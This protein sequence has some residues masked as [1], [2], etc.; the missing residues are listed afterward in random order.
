LT[1]VLIRH[2]YIHI[3]ALSQIQA[4]IHYEYVFFKRISEIISSGIFHTSP[5]QLVYTHRKSVIVS[6][7]VLTWCVKYDR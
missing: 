4:N 3:K 7:V 2:E 1:L 5:S 6:L